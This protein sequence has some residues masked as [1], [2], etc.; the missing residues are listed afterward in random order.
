MRDLYRCLDEYPPEFLQA[1]SGVWQVPLPEGEPKQM[2]VHLAEAMLAP[3]ALERTLQ[4]LTPRARG[5]LAEIVKDGG[6]APGHRLFV[7]YG[8]IRR[9]G[10]AAMEREQPWARPEGVLEEL[11]YKGVIYRAYAAV[12]GGYYGEV[13]FIPRDLL[14]P[15]QKLEREVAELDVQEAPAPTGIEHD[16]SA[17]AEDLLAFLVRIRQGRI[18]APDPERTRKGSSALDELDLGPRL[19]GENHPERL[20]LLRR[21][22]WRLHLLQDQKSILRPSPRARQWLRLPD[23]HRARSIYLA[24]RDDPHWDELDRVPSLRFDDRSRQTNPVV[25]RNSLLRVLA[26]CPAGQWLLLTSFLDALKHH[27][28]DFLRP[29]GDYDSWHVHDVQSGEYLSGFALWE[30]VEGALAI[31]TITSSLRWLGVVDLGYG[32][33]DAEPTAFRITDQGS[34]LL[35]AESQVPQAEATSSSSPPAAV[36]DDL[37]ITMSVT[38]SVYERYQLERFAQWQAQ[39]SLATYRITADCVWKGYNAGV[40]TA[41]IARFLKRITKDQVPPAVSRTLQAWGGRFGRAILRKTVLLQTKDESTMSQ[42]RSH[43]KAGGL[44]GETL[45]PTTSLVDEEN[46]DELLTQLKDMG[47][48]PLLID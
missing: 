41:Q 27:R 39:D 36:G 46:A 44:L 21:L 37:T 45:S 38:N 10:P 8:N 18:S 29:D 23:H 14:K 6:A 20:A 40:K 47:I 1:I 11:Y 26:K 12:V 25:A 43:E 35:P 15:L 9:L 17:L 2:V 16:G 32:G 24:W 7:K 4:G 34:S 48:W 5:A 33:E 42:V 19:V 3:D 28:P 31:H 30:K 13:Y 22:L